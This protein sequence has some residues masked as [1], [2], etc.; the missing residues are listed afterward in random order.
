MLR[1]IIALD[2][3][4]GAGKSA[5]GGRLAAH[6]GWLFVDTGIFYRVLTHQALQ[7]GVSTADEPAL[8][9]LV[10]ELQIQLVAHSSDGG[11]GLGVRVNGADVT[12]ALRAPPVDAEVSVV[13][14]L[15]QVRAALIEPQRSAVGEQ[16]AVVAGR[17]IGTVIFPD[18]GLKIYLDASPAERARRRRAQLEAE[19]ESLSSRRVLEDLER[20]DRRDSTRADAPLALAADALPLCTDGLSV[21]DVVA[22]IMELWYARAKNAG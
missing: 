3:P 22:Q 20:R 7:R 14:A 21:D 19:G 1:Q 10:R 6:L 16:A 11:N 4:A 17:D 8:V 2:G 18:A 9:E 13:A 15:S 12:G 5:V